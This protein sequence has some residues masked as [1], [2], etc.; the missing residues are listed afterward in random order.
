MQPLPVGYFEHLTELMMVCLNAV[1]HFILE[2]ST[3]Q[4]A[5][6]NKKTQAG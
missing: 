4:I 6:E 1:T 2:Y 5:V 3:C